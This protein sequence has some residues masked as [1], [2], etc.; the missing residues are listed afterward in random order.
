MNNQLHIDQVPT[1]IADKLRKMIALATDAKKGGEDRQGE[2]EAAMEAALKYSQR[3][4]INLE[5]FDHETATSTLSASAEAFISKAIK[6][7]KGNYRKPPCSKWV[8]A[9]LCD[10]F[11]VDIV[12]G[13]G[14]YSSTIYIIGRESAVLFAEW[15]YFHVVHQFNKLWRAY[16][17]ANFVHTSDRASYF[18]GLWVGLDSKLRKA[19][20]DGRQEIIVELSEKSITTQEETSSRYDLAIINEEASLKQAKANF[21]PVLIAGKGNLL[22]NVQSSSPAARRGIEDGGKIEFSKPLEEGKKDLIRA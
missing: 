8:V 19:K 7:A 18:Y 17:V 20:Q 2:F 16:S 3:H 1:N 12:Y 6:V 13:A 14:R 21:H 9:I 11:N 5:S 4:N 22:S 15:A 10:Y